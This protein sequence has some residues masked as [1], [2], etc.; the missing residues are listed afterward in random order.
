ME[1]TTFESSLNR[2]RNW[3]QISRYECKTII[4]EGRREEKSDG[5]REEKKSAEAEDAWH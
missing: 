5:V 3:M 4:L 2:M 1:K